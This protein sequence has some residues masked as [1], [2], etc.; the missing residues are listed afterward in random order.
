MSATTKDFRIRSSINASHVQLFKGQI[1]SLS[2]GLKNVIHY[3]RSVAGR[4]DL[5]RLT[6]H[7]SHYDRH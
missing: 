1:Q 4:S 5:T 6:K 3:I 2:R 7:M